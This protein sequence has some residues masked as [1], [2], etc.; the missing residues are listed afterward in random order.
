MIP[1]LDSH[2]DCLSKS[3]AQ[4]LRLAHFQGED[5]TPGQSCEGRVGPQR[6]CYSFRRTN[7]VDI[8]QKLTKLHQCKRKIPLSLKEDAVCWKA[9]S[10]LHT[11]SDGSFS[12]ARLAGDQYRPASNVAVFNHLQDDPCCTTGGQLADQSLRHLQV[13]KNGSPSLQTQHISKHSCTTGKVRVPT[14]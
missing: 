9:A 8:E 12:C 2:S 5:L 14:A 3:L 1:S 4:C 10:G 7:T 13:N 6:L 11:H